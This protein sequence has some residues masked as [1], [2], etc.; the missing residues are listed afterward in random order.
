VLAFRLLIRLNLQR[1]SP[2]KLASKL[3]EKKTG[4]A[5]L[6]QKQISAIKDVIDEKDEKLKISMASL[7]ALSPLSVLNRGYSIIKDDKGEILRDI[8][9]INVKDKLK[10][11]LANGKLEAEVL[12]KEK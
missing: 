6:R 11:R 2:L 8:S 7:D 1:I 10:I 9:R 3:N 5:L 4:L 12:R